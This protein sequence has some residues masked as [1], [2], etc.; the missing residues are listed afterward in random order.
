MIVV[1]DEVKDGILFFERIFQIVLALAIGEAFKQYFPER[2]EDGHRTIMLESTPALISFITLI[3]TFYLGMD[4][5]F[6]KSY[7]TLKALPDNYAI[8]LMF[9]SILFMIESALFFSMSRN[10]HAD[11]W[12]VFY[13]LVS[14]LL[15]VDIVWC[16]HGTI[17][18]PTSFRGWMLWDVIFMVFIGALWWFKPKDI[19]AACL[20]VAI[21]FTI[22]LISYTLFWPLYF[23]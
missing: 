1:T 13:L 11:R 14:L 23:A 16:I 19:C 6:F 18:G 21:T 10:L 22:T 12:R 3:V 4:R 15:I 20:G 17:I 7:I 8:H 5:Y 2:K 9:D